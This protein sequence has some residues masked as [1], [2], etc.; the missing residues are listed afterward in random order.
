[1]AYIDLLP[2]HSLRCLGSL[3]THWVHSEDWSDCTNVKADLSL[4]WVHIILLILSCCGS[5]TGRA[6]YQ[7]NFSIQYLYRYKMIDIQYI[8]WYF[9]QDKKDCYACNNN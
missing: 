6:A 9:M 1:M 8:I 2:D 4:R 5:V 7:S 3:A